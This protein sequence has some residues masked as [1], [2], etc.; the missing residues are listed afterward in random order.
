M[1]RDFHVQPDAATV[2]AIV[3]RHAPNAV[4]VTAVE[5]SGGE[6][7]TYAIDGDVI[8]KVQRRSGCAHEPPLRRSASSSIDWR[9]CRGAGAERHRGR[10]G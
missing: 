9:R 8:L 7:R 2:L 10:H 3:Q 1:A 6:A 5:E 4:A